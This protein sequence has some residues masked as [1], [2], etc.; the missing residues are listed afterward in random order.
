MNEAIYY[1]MS[2]YNVSEEDAIRYYSDEIKS[3]EALE[4][5]SE[6]NRR[7]GL[8]DSD[9]TVECNPHPDAPHGF[10]RNSSH[11]MNRYVCECESWEGNLE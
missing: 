1:V 10:D 4:R 5:L 8:Y 3:Y 2:M 7:L 9:E 6:E 11:N